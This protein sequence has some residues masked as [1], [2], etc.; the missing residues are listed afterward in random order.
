MAGILYSQSPAAARK[1]EETAEAVRQEA[2]KRKVERAKTAYEQRAQFGAEP[3]TEAERQTQ[4]SIAQAGVE[5]HR[6]AFELDPTEETYAAYLRSTGDYA[7]IAAL[8]EMPANQM[9]LNAQRQREAEEA[10]RAESPRV[11][12]A[13]AKAREAVAAEQERLARSRQF[14]EM[15][16]AGVTPEYGR[17]EGGR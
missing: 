11:A 9:V 14:A 1:R 13:R 16:T 10:A 2:E 8:P 6:G 12:E 15:V 17:R 5:A 7:E 3:E 4:L